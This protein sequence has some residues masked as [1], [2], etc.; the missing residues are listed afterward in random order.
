M[1]VEPTVRLTRTSVL[2]V[3]TGITLVVHTLVPEKYRFWKTNQS[4]V[5]K[6]PIAVESGP[7]GK[8]LVLDF[9][10]ESRETRVVELRLHQLVDVHVGKETF[11]D[12]RDLCFTNGTAFA[13]SF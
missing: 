13:G 8:V 3:L 12:A 11:K 2:E 7:Q 5:C 1:A 10:F 6:G 4:G 9:D